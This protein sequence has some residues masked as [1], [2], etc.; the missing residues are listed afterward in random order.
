MPLCT[1]YVNS[2]LGQWKSVRTPTDLLCFQDRS[3]SGDSWR[4]HTRIFCIPDRKTVH[5][6]DD[7]MVP[8]FNI[9][10]YPLS[11]LT[12][13][14]QKLNQQDHG[15]W[16]VSPVKF[17]WSCSVCPA[18]NIMEIPSKPFWTTGQPLVEIHIWFHRFMFECLL[19]FS[20]YWVE[21]QMFV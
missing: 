8:P 10:T 6:D 4:P 21:K 17:W 3:Q 12:S 11:Y 20:V 9:A 7:V 15:S 5:E 18:R 2:V 13:E 1:D 16:L 14:P 19:F